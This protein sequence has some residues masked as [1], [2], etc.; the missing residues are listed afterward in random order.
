MQQSKK[1]LQRHLVRN[2]VTGFLSIVM[3][4]SILTVL[5]GSSLLIQYTPVRVAY[6]YNVPPATDGNHCSQAC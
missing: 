3:L 5:I 1:S 6:A 4:L 2:L